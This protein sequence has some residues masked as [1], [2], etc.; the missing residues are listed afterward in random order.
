M[1]IVR[2]TRT[3]LIW[4]FVA[5]L[6]VRAL[7][8]VGWMPSSQEGRWVSICSGAGESQVWLDDQGAPHKSGD[9][10]SGDG[11]CVFA[12]TAAL[13]GTAETGVSFQVARYDAA[14]DAIAAAV[15]IGRG[16]AAPP[17]PQTGPPSFA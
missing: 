6:F 4:L 10:M 8:P 1:T 9:K 5:A 15:T 7:V 11:T 17:P 12:G 16:L 2:S 3:T 14:P 13:P